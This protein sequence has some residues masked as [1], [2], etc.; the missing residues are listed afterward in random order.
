MLVLAFDTSTPM[1]ACAL[2]E[3]G[4]DGYRM[5]GSG[6]ALAPR[7]ANTELVQ[8]VDDLLARCGCKPTDIGCVVCG[9]GPGSFTGVRIGIATAKGMEGASRRI[10]WR[11]RGDWRCHAG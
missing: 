8:R 7:R 1:L 9:R 5:L 6:D 3:V 10:P 2:A 4:A 11:A